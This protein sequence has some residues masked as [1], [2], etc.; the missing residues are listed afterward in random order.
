[1]LLPWL[2]ARAVEGNQEPSLHNALAKICIDTNRD[3]EDFLKNNAFYDSKVVG[4][5]CED[6]DPH[7]AFT[8]YK[9]NWGLCDQE[10]I[11]L[12]N[13]NGLFRL[14]ARYVQLI[15][16]RRAYLGVM[17][18]TKVKLACF[19]TNQNCGVHCYFH[20][21]FGARRKLSQYN[22]LSKWQNSV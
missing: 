2:E 10:L 6:R 12:T 21:F 11:E 8:A 18:K 13:R 15:D 14:Q 7:L 9:K 19:S 16:C 17:R 1:M 20:Q 5:Y 3:P 22:C 4:K